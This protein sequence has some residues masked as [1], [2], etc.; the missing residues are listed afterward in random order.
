MFLPFIHARNN[1]GIKLDIIVRIK[2][3]VSSNCESRAV[4]R[5]RKTKLQ[6]IFRHTEHT[7][8]Q[9]AVLFYRE[10]QVRDQQSL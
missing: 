7:I 3:I 5:K 9:L 4:E 1:H 2:E 10:E 6:E 8:S